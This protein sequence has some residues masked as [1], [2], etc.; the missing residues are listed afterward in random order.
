MRA[1]IR[2]VLEKVEA[3]IAG[4]HLSHYYC[5]CISR[6]LLTILYHNENVNRLYRTYKSGP[7]AGQVQHTIDQSK[8]SKLQPMV[9]YGKSFLVIFFQFI[10]APDGFKFF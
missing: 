9:T 3:Y 1:F 8:D 6:L 7:K 4:T 10:S 2:E 5:V